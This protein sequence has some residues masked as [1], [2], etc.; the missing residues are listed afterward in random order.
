MD[1]EKDLR[2]Q[3]EEEQEDIKEEVEVSEENK[4]LTKHPNLPG[5]DIKGG[6]YRVKG[7]IS[8]NPIFRR[9]GPNTNISQSCG[10]AIEE[11]ATGKVMYVTKREGVTLAAR[12]GM[13][14][15]YIIKRKRETKD[16]LGQV[17][18]T[19]ETVYLQPYPAREESFTQDGRL[20]SVFE[21]D[22]DNKIKYPLNMLIEEDQCTKDFWLLIQEIYKKRKNRRRRSRKI[23]KGQAESRRRRVMEIEAEIS[24]VDIKN[25]FDTD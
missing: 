1:K 3:G 22:E 24:K 10:Y 21:L 19:D 17:I 20:I 9:K 7:A 12:H 11:I 14:N 25:P 5:L 15:G 16:S 13:A 8:A 23:E 18:K 6:E 2:G 4:A